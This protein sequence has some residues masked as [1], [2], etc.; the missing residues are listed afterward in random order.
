[1]CHPVQSECNNYHVKAMGVSPAAQSVRSYQLKLIKMRAEL[2]NLND[3][4][5]CSALLKPRR[6]QLEL[7]RYYVLPPQ[8]MIVQL[9]SYHVWLRTQD[10]SNKTRYYTSHKNNSCEK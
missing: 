6:C 4:A 10:L 1:M 2:A 7:V 5:P 3:C 8:V 9:A